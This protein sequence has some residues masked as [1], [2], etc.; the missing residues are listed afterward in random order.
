MIFNVR[1]ASVAQIN[2]LYNQSMQKTSQTHNMPN[3]E[4]AEDNTAFD[5][6]MVHKCN[7]IRLLITRQC[8]IKRDQRGTIG[9]LS[10]GLK[11]F[12]SSFLFF[13][14]QHQN[15]CRCL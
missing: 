9:S 14:A 13:L 11:W 10:Q 3:L 5:V 12:V 2:S 7:P 8:R 1:K 15:D 4:T 6:Q